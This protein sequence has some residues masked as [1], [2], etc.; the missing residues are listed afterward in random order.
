[1]EKF[2]KIVKIFFIIISFLLVN[3]AIDATTGALVPMVVS[4][5]KTGNPANS[6]DYMVYGLLFGQLVKFTILVFYMEKRDKTFRIRLDRPYILKEKIEKPS[7][8]VGIGFGTVGFGLILTNIIMKAFE[9]TDLMKVAIDLM[10]NAFKGESAIDGIIILMVIALGAP[11]VEELLFRGVLFEEINRETSKI[12]TIFLTAFI[13]GIYHFNIIQTPN[14]FFMGLV[15]A[16]LYDKTKSIKAP[17]IV[18]A[19]NNIMATI[20]LIDRGLSIEG[21]IIYGIFIIIGIYSF[22]TLRQN[23]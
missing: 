5:I 2:K 18:H 15:L 7:Y 3:I 21:L 10:E 12:M 11:V 14:T 1:M 13:F 19:T 23:A 16:Y 6:I 17:M 20:P 4:I 8:L 22:K 9:N